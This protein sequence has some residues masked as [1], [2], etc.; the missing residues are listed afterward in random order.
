MTLSRRRH[1]R[2]VQVEQAGARRFTGLASTSVLLLALSLQA[3]NSFPAVDLSP[4]YEPAQ[5][6]VPASWHG[7]SP[8]VE[9]KPSDAE[10]RQDWWKLF[11]DP[12]LNKLEAQAL[13]ANP[14][15]QAAAERF[16]QSRDVMMKA[17]SQ[18]LPRVGLGSTRPIIGSP[19]IVCFAPLTA[20]WKNRVWPAA[21]SRL[22]SLT[23]GRRSATRHA[24]KCTAPKNAPPTSVSR[25]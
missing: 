20:H 10:L 12:V 13:T 2:C 16:V 11:N 4:P 21:G 23:S 19:S 5:F 18:Y 1:N 24:W 14:D 17:R 22:G 7:S 15:L 9:A 6:V 25:A 8:F 3:C